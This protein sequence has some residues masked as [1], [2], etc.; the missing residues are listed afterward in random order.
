[1]FCIKTKELLTIGE[2]NAEYKLDVIYSKERIDTDS[3]ELSAIFKSDTLL[4]F[5]NFLYNP[6]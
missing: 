2:Y 3:E 4:K 1:M 5:N 6:N